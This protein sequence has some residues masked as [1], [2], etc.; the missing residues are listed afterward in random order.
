MKKLR[1]KDVK[2]I[3]QG[4]K[5]Q[6]QNII[7]MPKP[8][9]FLSHHVPLSGPKTRPFCSCFSSTGQ[10]APSPY[11]VFL[12]YKVIYYYNRTAIQFIS[13]CTRES[14]DYCLVQSLTPSEACTS[15]QIRILHKRWLDGLIWKLLWVLGGSGWVRCQPTS[16]PRTWN[17][18]T[19]WFSF[20]WN[21]MFG[22]AR[23]SLGGLGYVSKR[24]TSFVVQ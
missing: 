21:P 11:F 15:H 10:S 20:L 9:C 7:L 8:M 18:P 13:S 12:I 22:H 4:H 24:I 19:S 2:P 23:M 3:A 5:W 1:V 14:K 6:R 17:Q 16:F